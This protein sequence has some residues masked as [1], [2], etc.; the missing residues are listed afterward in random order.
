MTAQTYTAIAR[1][2]N[3]K[4]GN[5]P[6]I[7]RPQWSCPS[8][9]PLMGA[10]CYGE[11]KPGRPSI[12]QMVDAS[13]ANRARKSR[14]LSMR[15]LATRRW[16]TVPRALRFGVVGDYLTPAG[17]PD[18]AYIAE[19]N[20]L[21]TA[22]P[23]VSWGYTHAWRRLVPSMFRYVVRASVQSAQ[24][25]S[26]A[27][28]AGWRVAIVDP[29]PDAPDTLIGSRI[30]GQLVVQCPVTNGKSASCEDCRLCGRDVPTIIAFPV[31]GAQ[32]GKAA[33]AVRATRAADR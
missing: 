15:D 27:I 24:E 2:G 11:V 12:F 4:I 6:A 32:R 20:E 16:R 25:A 9:C 18:H 7:S 17:T 19:T 5:I 1:S 30:D 28:A 29:G 22:H 21:A 13:I 33:R 3:R 26:A 31:H 10:G 23:W 8:D 14:R